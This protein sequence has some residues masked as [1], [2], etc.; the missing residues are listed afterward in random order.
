[1]AGAGRDQ[2]VRDI[3][4]LGLARGEGRHAL[5]HQDPH[6]RLRVLGVMAPGQAREHQFAAREVAA[7]VAEVGGHHAA[8]RA[9]QLF[10]AAEQLE[11]QRVGVQQCAQPHSR[12]RRSLSRNQWWILWGFGVNVCSSGW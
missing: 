4:E 12:R 8:H 1:M 2:V 7:G 6:E 10:L 5:L 9:V 11:A 3:P